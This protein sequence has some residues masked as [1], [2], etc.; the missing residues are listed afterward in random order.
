M[1]SAIRPMRDCVSTSGGIGVE[2]PAKSRFLKLP[3]SPLSDSYMPLPG[4]CSDPSALG[5]VPARQP[6][7]ASTAPGAALAPVVLA[8]AGPW[9]TTS[10]TMFARKQS[11]SVT[12]L[13]AQSPVG[14]LTLVKLWPA[15]VERNR[16]APV[17]A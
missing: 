11:L 2:L 1:P 10:V 17:A 14:R 13:P 4:D 7:A 15:S 5:L 8:F 3:G 16:P 12:G 9:T 6:T